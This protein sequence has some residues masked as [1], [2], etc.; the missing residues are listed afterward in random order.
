M[1]AEM[2]HD[3]DAELSPRAMTGWIQQ[4]DND[5]QGSPAQA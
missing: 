2:F 3:A 1:A 5:Y 4:Q